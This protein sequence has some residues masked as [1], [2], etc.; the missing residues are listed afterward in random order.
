MVDDEGGFQI[1]LT[2]LA[3]ECHFF[4]RVGGIAVE[5][6]YNSLPEAAKIAHV[7][8]QIGEAFSQTFQVGLRD[9]IEGYPTVHLQPL[10]GSH[11]DS[12]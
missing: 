9:S 7:L 12:E 11:E 4:V 10:C 5:H 1:F 2:V 3:Q 6:Y 8:I